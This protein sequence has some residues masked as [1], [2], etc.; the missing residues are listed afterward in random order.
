MFLEQHQQKLFHNCRP[1]FHICCG[2]SWSPADEF[3]PLVRTQFLLVTK[4][5]VKS[6]CEILYPYILSLPVLSQSVSSNEAL[7]LLISNYRVYKCRSETRETDRQHPSI[8]SKGCFIQRIKQMCSKTELF[9]V[10]FSFI[11]QENAQTKQ[12]RRHEQSHADC[13]DFIIKEEMRVNRGFNALLHYNIT[14]CL[15]SLIF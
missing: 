3:T 14:I 6:S 4:H 1:D 15:F 5:L 10:I 8:L 11:S 13:H 2:H 7:L 12:T 9:S